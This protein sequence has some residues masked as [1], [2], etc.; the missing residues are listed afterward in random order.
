MN[1]INDERISDILKDF[2]KQNKIS[3]GYHQVSVQEAWDELMDDMIKK[4]T[5][6]LRFN[7][8][9]LFIKLKSASL[10]QELF[11]NKEQL[12]SILNQKLGQELI[13]EIIFN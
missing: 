3:K 7:S 9:K 10:K 1:R 8:G 6:S 12:I 13:R 2:V 11:A 5:Q 4:Y